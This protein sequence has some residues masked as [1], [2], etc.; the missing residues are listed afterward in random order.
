MVDPI[1]TVHAECWRIVIPRWQPYRLNQS[2]GRHWSVE[3]KLK[4]IDRQLIAF[5]GRGLPMAGCKRSVRLQI[6]L[7][8][9]QRGGDPDG[10]WKGL[11]DNLV[12]LGHL[13]DDSRKWCVCLP[14]EFV[15]GESRS[16]T[17]ELRDLGGTP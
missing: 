6:T 9:K 12:E 4:K 8:P 10:Y 3:A 7:G 17:I 13:V 14:V 5:Y 15:R 1:A 16:T 2:R 11:L